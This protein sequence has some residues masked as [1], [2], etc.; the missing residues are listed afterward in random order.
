M[1]ARKVKSTLD[2]D[3]VQ[4]GCNDGTRCEGS[5]DRFVECVR[6]AV[7]RQEPMAAYHCREYSCH[8]LAVSTNVSSCAPRELYYIFLDGDH[9]ISFIEENCA[10]TSSV[11]RLK[12]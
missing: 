10:R 4:K 5:E 1:P 8:H 12:P 6:D 9:R 2:A 3:Q 11:S 7:A